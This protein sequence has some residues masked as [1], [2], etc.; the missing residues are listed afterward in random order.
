MQDI[1]KHCRIAD[2]VSSMHLV[3]CRTMHYINVS[4]ADGYFTT[5]KD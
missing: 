1:A 5:S 2:G 4:L 3:F